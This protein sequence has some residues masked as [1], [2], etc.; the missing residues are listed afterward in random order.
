MYRLFRCWGRSRSTPFL[1]FW[2][3]HLKKSHL[4]SYTQR[5]KCDLKQCSHMSEQSNKHSHF[6]TA[7]D[8]GSSSKPWKVKIERPN[9][10]SANEV[11]TW[12]DLDTAG[13]CRSK[14]L[15]LKLNLQSWNREIHDPGPQHARSTGGHFG[16]TVDHPTASSNWE[17]ISGWPV[18]RISIRWHAIDKNANAQTKS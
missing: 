11:R 7:P 14:W 5:S 13:P 17:F 4:S 6:L 2:S 15:W 3:F 12:T 9:D 16:S 18:G 1:L 10:S 8:V